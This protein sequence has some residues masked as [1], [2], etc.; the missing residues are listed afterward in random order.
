MTM[1]TTTT[2]PGTTGNPEQLS[3]ANTLTHLLA[4][5]KTIKKRLYLQCESIA[6]HSKLLDVHDFSL[7]KPPPFLIELPSLLPTF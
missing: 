4:Q 2:P 1:S 6:H 5:L 7:P 3:V